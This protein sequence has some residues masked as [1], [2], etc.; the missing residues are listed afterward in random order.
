MTMETKFCK[1]CGIEKMKSDFYIQRT[2]KPYLR[3]MCKKCNSKAGGI[4]AKIHKKSPS[5]YQEIARSNKGYKNKMFYAMQ[6]RIKTREVYKDFK[7]DFSR[8]E[9]Y[10]FVDTTDFEKMRLAWIASGYDR[11][12]SPSVDRINPKKGYSINNIQIITVSEN[13]KRKSLLYE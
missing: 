8:E 11:K 7:I 3:A 12:L 1:Y 10:K 13:S 6:N 5:E 4:H 9:F 2:G